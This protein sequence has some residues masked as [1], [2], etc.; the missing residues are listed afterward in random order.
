MYRL[1][2]TQNNATQ[3]VSRSRISQPKHLVC[4]YRPTCPQY[5]KQTPGRCFRVT[6]DAAHAANPPLGRP[7]PPPLPLETRRPPAQPLLPQTMPRCSQD[8]DDTQ[9]QFAG[10]F[11]CLV[12]TTVVADTLFQAHGCPVC[13]VAVP[14]AIDTRTRFVEAVACPAAQDRPAG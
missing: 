5:G 1:H 12:Q 14:T 3:N 7:K 8:S 2:R 6:T 9:L 4:T 11:L 10:V 13:D